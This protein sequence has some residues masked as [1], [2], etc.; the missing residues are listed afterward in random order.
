MATPSLKYVSPPG[1]PSTTA[2]TFAWIAAVVALPQIESG[3][4][5]TARCRAAVVSF[6]GGETYFKLG[7]AIEGGAL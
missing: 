2:P 4:A 7:V 1:M 3:V 5:P 6:P